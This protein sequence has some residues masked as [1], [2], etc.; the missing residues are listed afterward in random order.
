MD[1]IICHIKYTQNYSLEVRKGSKCSLWSRL[2]QQTS[3]VPNERRQNRFSSVIQSLNY[4]TCTYLLGNICSNGDIVIVVT[5]LLCE[6]C[7][8][9]EPN[10]QGDSVWDNC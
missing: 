5:A 6:G 4:Y 10:A 2:T 3:F 8:Y 1:Y 7:E 9:R